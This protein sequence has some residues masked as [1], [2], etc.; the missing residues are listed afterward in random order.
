MAEY[1]NP[2]L[3]FHALSSKIMSKHASVRN[4][5]VDQLLDADSLKDFPQITYANSN[6][7]YDWCL[8]NEANSYANYDGGLLNELNHDFD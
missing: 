1:S 5:R 7:N 2:S 4:N 8:L 3:L 6:A